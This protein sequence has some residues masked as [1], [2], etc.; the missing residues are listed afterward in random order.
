MLHLRPHSMQ[1]FEPVLFKQVVP[2]DRAAAEHLRDLTG[3]D[4]LF[5]VAPE[6]FG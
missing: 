2:A 1:A 5:C 4:V 3:S 6:R